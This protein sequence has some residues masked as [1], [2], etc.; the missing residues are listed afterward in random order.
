MVKIRM[1][2]NPLNLV[3]ETKEERK[4]R[5]HKSNLRTRVVESKKRYN[6]NKFKRGENF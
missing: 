4:E 2:S 3:K 1:K 6:R 5:I